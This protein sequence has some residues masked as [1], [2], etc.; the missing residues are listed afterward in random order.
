[1][2]VDTAAIRRLRDHLLSTVA[3]NDPSLDG[4]APETASRDA[5]RHRVEPFAE[6]M[7]LMMVAD[8]DPASVEHRTLVAAIQVL[9][10]G[11]LTATDV[12]VMVTQFERNMRRDGSEAR[13]AEIGERVGGDRTD[14]ETAFMLGAVVALADDR[15]DAGENRALE[16]IKDYFGISKGR[17]DALLQTIA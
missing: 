4:E 2:N 5:I 17:M 16:W 13:L 9:T 10:D 3:G 14:R 1:M 11:Q 7:Y 6:T 15:V 8:G 12:D